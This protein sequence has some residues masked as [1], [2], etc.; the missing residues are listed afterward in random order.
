MGNWFRRMMAGRNGM[1]RLGLVLIVGALL[2]SMLANLFRS[3]VL[4]LISWA[5]LIYAIFRILSRNTAAR[6]KEDQAVMR[7]WYNL[8]YKKEKPPKPVK[9]KKPKEDRKT[10]RYYSC[11]NCKQRLRV[12]RGKGR[13]SI[14]C[15]KCNKSFI[16]K[17]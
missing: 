16:K 5:L 8:K 1:D 7:F 9:T 13:I 15:P 14:T 11:P 3:R 6:Q 10:Y 17:S 12:P 4:R 2:F